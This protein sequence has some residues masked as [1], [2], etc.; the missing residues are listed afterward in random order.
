MT[1]RDLGFDESR[2]ERLVQT[3]EADVDAERYDGAAVVV[4][5]RGEIA[6]HE[7][8]GFAERTSQRRARTDDVFCLFSVHQDLHY[9]GC[10]R[11]GRS[12]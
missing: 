3:I 7:A 1:A 9:R 6:L 4:A 5:R 2:L 12:R 8:V 11:P 10:T